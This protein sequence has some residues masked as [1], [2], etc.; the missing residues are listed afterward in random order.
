MSRC[1]HCKHLTPEYK[2][3]GEAILKDSSLKSR[4][5]IGKVDPHS[6]NPPFLS[7]VPHFQPHSSMYHSHKTFTAVS[8]C[9]D[10]DMNTS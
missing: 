7:I 4:V 9:L 5:V 10:T 6:N 2:K 8:S 1:G 3:L